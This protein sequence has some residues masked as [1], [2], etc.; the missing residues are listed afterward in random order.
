MA[1]ERT[2]IYLAYNASTPIAAAVAA[3]MRPLVDAGFGN[4]SSGHWAGR[5]ARDAID[6]ARA[7]VASL[8]GCDPGEIVLT[9]GGSEANNQ[10]VKSLALGAASPPHIVT[11]AV[12]HPAILEPCRFVETLGAR[13]T[14]V[15]V[16]RHG[17]VDPDDVRRA[18]TPRTALVSVMHANNEVG[19]IQ[20]VAEI[21]RIAREH[22][23][24]CHTDAAQSAGKIPVRVAELGVDL[25]SLAGHKLYAPKGVGALFVRRG[26]TLP[27]LVHGGGHE[28]GRRAG[29]ESALLAAGLGAACRLAETAPCEDRLRGLRDR[30]WNGLAA[31]LGDRIVLIGRCGPISTSLARGTTTRAGSES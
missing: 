16:D 17:L 26:V 4:P 27:P 2:R 5:P 24:L 10:V 3:A 22:G 23:V 8:L 11:T 21:A 12:E 28:D 9:S 7:R 18:I 29:T 15:P 14:V 20:P 19:T 1:Q 6:A 13:V 30:L 31:R 25:L